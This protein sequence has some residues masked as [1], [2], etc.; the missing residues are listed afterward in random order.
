MAGYKICK[1]CLENKKIDLFITNKRYKSGIANICKECENKRVKKWQENNVDKVKLTR[2]K[3][4]LV[5]KEEINKRHRLYNIEHKDSMSINSR[6]F[7]EKNKQE[8]YSKRNNR[9]RFNRINNTIFKLSENCSSLIR[10]SMRN[11]GYK[12]SSRAYE[13]LG[14]SFEDFKLYLESKFESWMT[15]EN[16]GKYNG[17]LSFGWD[18]DHIIPISKAET[19]DDIIK[20]NHYSNLQPLC[21]KINRDIKKNNIQWQ[22]IPEVFL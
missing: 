15:W 1:K 22:D 7:Y 13:I 16:Y 6:K 9:R 3:Y 4:E 8:I 14:C 2:K 10:N 12:K 11:K 21:S 19:E 18:M 5:N 17:E 20:L